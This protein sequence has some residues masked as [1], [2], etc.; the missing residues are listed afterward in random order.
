MLA[1]DFDSP[2][3]SLSGAPLREIKYELFSLHNG[4]LT[5]ISQNTAQTTRIILAETNP[6]NPNTLICSNQTIA[7]GGCQSPTPGCTPGPTSFCD[8]PGF[9]TDQLSAGNSGPN[10]VTQQFS[11][12][13]GWVRVYWP[14][15]ASNGSIYWYGAYSQTAAV[16]R[17]NI[18]F[19][20][21]ARIIQVNPDLQNGAS[22]QSGCSFTQANGTLLQP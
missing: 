14:Q 19:P 5:P 3:Y 4:L 11:V 18:P 13:R 17:V 15:K 7:N 16:D 22:C 1:P 12:D 6:T 21:G 20:Q 8:S 9:L 2:S 10:T